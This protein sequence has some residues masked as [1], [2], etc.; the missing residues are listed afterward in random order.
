MGIKIR[1]DKKTLDE[2]RF[3]NQNWKRVLKEIVD[4]APNRYGR[5]KSNYGED[6]PLVKRLKIKSHELVLIMSFLEEQDLIEYD[7]FEHN[8]I[9]LT[10]KGFDVARH[11]QAQNTSFRTNFV[12]ILL[13]AIIAFATVVNVFTRI[14]DWATRFITIGFTIGLGFIFW[15]VV[16]RTA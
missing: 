2:W 4:Y 3:T 10:S 5:G 16:K 13:T 6:H 14:D 1:K 7:K 12:I 9:N 15:R 8:W 11:N